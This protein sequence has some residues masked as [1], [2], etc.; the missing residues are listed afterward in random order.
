MLKI[1]IVPQKN[2]SARCGH[3]MATA[4][5]S[6]Q[7]NTKNKQLE[8]P[9]AAKARDLPVHVNIA[10]AMGGVYSIVLTD[11]TQKHYAPLKDGNK[12]LTTHPGRGT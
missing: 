7:Y 3:D 12:S 6:A 9:S 8:I 11:T 10:S 4:I 1:A 2:K 5:H